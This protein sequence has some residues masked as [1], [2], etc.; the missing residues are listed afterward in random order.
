MIVKWHE[1]SLDRLAD[2]Y[3]DAIPKDREVIAAAVTWMNIQ[4]A[5]GPWNLGESREEWERIWFHYP[6]A[7]MY[8][9]L[10]NDGEVLVTDVIKLRP[11]ADK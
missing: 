1:Q 11:Q 7:I 8:E 4:L 2:I 3:V 5:L 6:L 9:I 10:P